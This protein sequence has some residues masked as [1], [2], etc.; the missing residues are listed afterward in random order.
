MTAVLIVAFDGLQPSQIDPNRMPVLS[1]FADA[2]V[3][4][5]HNHSVFPSVTRT[6]SATIVTGVRPGKHGLTANKS[7]FP[8]YSTNQVV[9]AL[10]PKLS[11]INQLTKGKLLFV[12]TI[13]EVIRKHH[14]QWVSVVGGTSGN[15]YVQHPNAAENGHVVI[16]PEFTNP[17][18]HS[19]KIKSQYGDWPSKKA[20]AADLIRR[21][22]DVAI[23]YALTELNPDVLMVWF[24]EPDTSQHAFGVDSPEAR[25][26]IELADRE[27]GRILK[28]VSQQGYEPDVFIVSDHGYSTIDSVIDVDKELSAGGFNIGS[29]ENSVVA[30]DNGGSVLFYVP[31][32]DSELS[33][34]LLRWLSVQ[35]WVGS[36]ATDI[37]NDGTAQFAT[38]SDIGLRGPRAPLIVVTMRSSAS[39]EVAPLAS[40]GAATGGKVGLGSHGGGSSAELH[41]TLIV[42]GPSFKSDYRSKIPSGN[43]DI[44]PTILH[45]FDIPVPGHFDGRVLTEALQHTGIENVN[46]SHTLMDESSKSKTGAITKAQYLHTEYMCQ[47]G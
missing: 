4:F 27:L 30:A 13:G 12:P 7:M 16:H 21:T 40:L 38:L 43:V 39:G 2:G 26:M 22:A 32:A 3:R 44:A 33:A 1:K 18:V 45:L 11:E 17:S 29:E 19:D 42:R 36:I 20:P 34:R 28:R 6:N 46:N 15:A 37:P 25:R 14:L 31:G 8:E 41:N 5:L 9:D 23:G 35:R 24:P 10:H 47:F